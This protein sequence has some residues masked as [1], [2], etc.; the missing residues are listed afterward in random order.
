MVIFGKLFFNS[1]TMRNFYVMLFLFCGVLQ[2][3][4]GQDYSLYFKVKTKSVSK[5]FPSLITNKNWDDASVVDLISTSN[6]G[7]SLES[8]TKAG[9]SIFIQPNGAWGWN[10]GS[11]KERLD[12]LPS[13]LQ[14]INDGKSHDIAISFYK[15]KKTAWLYFDGR[16]VAIYSLSELGMK[17]EDITKVISIKSQKDISIKKLKEGKFEQ[18]ANS[19][20]LLYNS[21][22]KTSLLYAQDKPN[23][24][25]VMSWNIWHGA[26][27]NGVKK[28]I[29]QAISAIRTSGADL[30]CM[31]E[32]YGSGPA[33]SDALGTLFYY[34]SSNLS[35]HSKYPIVDTYDAYQ[36]F[37]FGGVRVKMGSQFVDV[38]SLWIHYLPSISKLYPT[39]TVEVILS[40][41][42]KT[43]GKEIK[44][45]IASLQK[46]NVTGN[47]V[48]LIIGGD[49]NSPSH[50]DWGDDMKIY[51]HNYTI[52]WPVS[53]SMADDGFVDSFREM[54]PNPIYSIGNTWS[55]RFH[56]SMQQ[57]IDYLYY[58]GNLNCVNSYVK[59]YTDSEWPSDHAAIIA[60][61]RFK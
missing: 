26:R 10:I 2:T 52:E 16:H 53:K 60:E 8:G 54:A 9:W 33:I 57:R 49:F 24:L 51:H 15:D 28:G 12:Y 5:D 1:F 3:A 47:S 45:I 41:E 14:R 32:T 43:R 38:F 39:E 37:R 17:W 31:Q 61:Y 13:T 21:D 48:P 11:G 35:V 18:N 4:I 46:I 59:G 36:S 34:R 7:L 27:H 40:E 56:E 25:T 20:A 6:M 44:E 29:E 19:V 23:K 30:V 50:L 22:L 58:K 42:N 55:P